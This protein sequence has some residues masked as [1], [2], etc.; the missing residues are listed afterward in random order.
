MYGAFLTSLC[1]WGGDTEVDTL[2][3][4]IE[5]VSIHAPRFRE[6]MDVTL[7]RGDVKRVERLHVNHPLRTGN[8]ERPHVPALA[9]GLPAGTDRAMN[10]RGSDRR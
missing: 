4:G 8:A 6:A 7:G 10:T 5:L 1:F 9:P 3:E 2:G